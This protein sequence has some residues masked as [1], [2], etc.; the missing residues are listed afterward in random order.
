MTQ[1][2]AISAQGTSFFIAGTGG[3]GKTITGVAVGN[4][5]VIT[6]AAHGFANG[7]SV[8]LTG[9]T[10]ADAALLNSKTYSVQFKTTNTFCVA[11]DTTGKVITAAGTATTLANIPI[12]N[13]KSGTGMDG[14]ANEIDTTHLLSTAKEFLLGLMDSGSFSL[15]IDLDNG[16]P[17][18]LALRAAQQSGQKKT[19]KITL[20]TGP[21][22]NA[23]FQGLVKKMSLITGDDQTVKS[24]IEVRVTGPVTWA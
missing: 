7:D 6:S 2:T 8:T 23:S 21:T 16:D 1:S 3:A 12:A 20:P 10:G 17:G 9:L 18:H 19:F 13:V 11:E 14:T 4:P 15:D 22:P 5:T 24:A